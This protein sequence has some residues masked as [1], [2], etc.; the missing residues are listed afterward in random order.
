M[1]QAYPGEWQNQFILISLGHFGEKLHADPKIH[2]KRVRERGW[3]SQGDGVIENFLCLLDESGWGQRG[4]HARINGAA[5]Q[6]L[7]RIS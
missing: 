4:V 5:K 7:R 3:D 6:K 1:Q 2:N